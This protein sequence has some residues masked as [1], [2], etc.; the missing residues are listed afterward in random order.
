MYKRILVP[1]DGSPTAEAGLMEAIRLARDQGARLR[2]LYVVEEN[3]LAQ[4]AGLDGSALYLGAMLDSM[5][6]AGREILA[7]GL[8]LARERAV[9]A[10]APDPARFFG[11]SADRIVE[12][13]GQ[14]PADLIVMGTHGRRGISRVVMGSDAEIVART[15]PVPVLL[16]RAPESVPARAR[17]ETR[18]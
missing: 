16:V 17:T 6:A 5:I 10:E 3:V 8:A 15:T 18:T 1:I 4:T 11:R 13:A 12:E 7:R 9:E 2:L 14:W